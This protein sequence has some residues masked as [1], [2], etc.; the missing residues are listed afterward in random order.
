MQPVYSN[1]HFRFSLLA[2]LLASVA[3][4]ALADT[5]LDDNGLAVIVVTGEKRE[6][7]IQSA[8]LAISAVS[9]DALTQSGVNQLSDINGIVPS[10]VVAKELNS[11]RVIA[12]RGVGYETSSNASSQPG[13][14]FHIDG[15]YMTSQ[16][17]AAMAFLDV[18][19]VE[20]LRGPQGTVFGQSS[21]GGAVN[22][23]GNA[24]KIGELSGD[25]AVS[26]GTYSLINPRGTLNVPLGDTMALRVSGNYQH[27]DG[28][29]KQTG[30]GYNYDLD[31]AN[32][33]SGKATLLWQPSSDFSLK[34]SAQH[35]DSSV[36]GSAEKE[37]RDP[38][39]DPRR[40]S[41]D[42]PNHSTAKFTLLYGEAAYELPFAT[43]KYL[44]SYQRIR[45]SDA[46]DNDRLNYATLG[47]YDVVPKSF[48]HIEAQTHE[49]NLVSKGDGPLQFIAGGFYMRRVL[50]GDFVEFFGFDPD[51]VFVIPEAPPLP[52]NLSYRVESNQVH[53]N[54]AL[55]GQVSYAISDRMRVTGGLR[56]SRDTF[57]T[58]SLTTYGIFGPAV[59]LRPRDNALTGNAVIDFDLSDDS[60]VYL[61]YARGYKPGGVNLNSFPAIVSLTF[62]PERVDAFEAGSKNVFLDGGLSV[63]AAAFYYKYRNFQYQQEDP[64]PYQGG[65]GNI[66]KSAIWG[67]ELEAAYVVPRL[68]LEGSLT[69]LKGEIKSDYLTLDPSR[70][71]EVTNEAA[72]MGY[73][74]FDP[75]TIN[76]RAQQIY[77]TKGNSLPKLPEWGARAA[78]SYT[79]PLS[80]SMSLLGRVEYIYRGSYSYRIFD[81]PLRDHVPSYNVVNLFV[82]LEMNSGLSLSLTASNLFNKDGIS[83]RFSNPFGIAGTTNSYIPPRQV[84]GTLK[85]SF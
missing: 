19:R 7:T 73:G 21:T 10:L 48:Y 25:F 18:Q 61:R 49:L 54:Y 68:R 26:A 56:Y 71:A 6:T 60:K 30:L 23:I 24:P 65:V 59:E 31:D 72:F 77:N 40:I 80:E 32:D 41:Q 69:W 38:D 34:L 33:K 53:K 63:N 74:M 58:T 39:P 8:P 42:Y 55:F 22:V 79:L 50:K 84:F 43:V 45:T 3:S 51:P 16:L 29:A 1:P 12:I 28:F 35:Y 83:S 14:S 57:D 67:A 11:Q 70:A 17:A 5:A 4:P 47:F 13:V 85:Y 64:I 81:D 36:H 27:R 66:P 78:A 37:L 2:G 15:V 76:L 9:Q 82:E 20:V 52:A 46:L 62:K 75:Y 44:A